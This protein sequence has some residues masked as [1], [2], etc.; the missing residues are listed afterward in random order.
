[1][2]TSLTESMICYATLLRTAGNFRQDGTQ[3]ELTE[4]HAGQRSH[5]HQA[6]A[7]HGLM[8]VAE[9]SS[10][11]ETLRVASVAWR[12]RTIPAIIVSRSSRGRPLSF[13][14]AIKVLACCAASASKGATR[15]SISSSNPSKP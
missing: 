11:R 6:I 4:Y 13:R 7:A 1:M 8:R 14:E 9:T 5:G 12:A 10:K 15:W 3:L 2:E